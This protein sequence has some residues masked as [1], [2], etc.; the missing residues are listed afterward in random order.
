MNL[1][2]KQEHAVYF[3]KDKETNELVYGG[4]AGGGKSKLGV[5]WL[6]ECCQN[7]PGTRWLLGRSKLK[8]LKETTLN[9]FL[10]T[11]SELGIS[12]QFHLNNQSGIITHVNGSEIILKDLFHYPSD[13]NYDS[14][15]SLEITGAFIDECNQITHK[16]WQI[17]KS[18]IR[19]KLKE[20]DLIPKLLGT[21]NPSK[22]WVY[23][24][25]YK[26]YKDQTIKTNRRFIQALPTDNPHLPPSYI[27]SLL[28]L[29]KNSKER[30]YYGNWEYDNDPSAL[31]SYDAIKDYFNSVHVKPEGY[32][33]ITCDVARKGK[34]KTVIRVWHGWVCIKRL[35]MATSL[36][37]EIVDI[38]TGLESSYG[39]P[40]SRVIVDEDG[41]GGGV[42]DYLECQGFVN[43]SRPL[44]GENYDNL[45]SQCSIKMAKKIEL[46]EVIENCE[47]DDIINTISEELEQVKQKDI[48]KDGKMAI[49]P[50]D[51]IKEKLG[52][53]PDD[54]DSIMMRYWFE[55][56]QDATMIIW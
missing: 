12:N 6:I 16:A 15:G 2:L 37:N 24:L 42:V 52:R 13:P 21:C 51:L 29:D 38:I 48:D 41:V 7:Y 18:R 34:D 54:W 33:Y 5:L 39:I 22:G 17:V 27:Q 25:F 30:L 49:I 28:E 45:K 53:S 31:I 26:P 46:R 55:L 44:N 9:T 23:R 4:A 11:C 35:E 19:Y 36:V 20:Y 47:I 10:D 3:L 43:N 8:A 32:K 40:R 14:L 50:K 1:L 56:E